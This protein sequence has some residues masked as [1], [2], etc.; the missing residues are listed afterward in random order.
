MGQR[1]GG[2]LAVVGGVC[3]LAAYGGGKVVDQSGSPPLDQGDSVA[4]SDADANGVRDDLDAII[5]AQSFTTSQ[6]FA[7]VQAARALRSGM[8]VD[9]TNADAV[10]QA[11]ARF[12]RGIA[13]V[14]QQFDAAEAAAQ[15]QW[16][17][18]LSTNT[19][20]RLGAYAQ[21]NRVWAGMPADGAV[22]SGGATHCED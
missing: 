20:V 2:L 7:L 13:C 9:L 6:K 3:W 17:R 21:F 14:D 15:M 19:M 18:Q 10:R 1:I 16:I 4:G 5:A 8:T 22:G 11:A 12:T